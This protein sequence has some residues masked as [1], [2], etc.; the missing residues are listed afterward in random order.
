MEHTKQDHN[1]NTIHSLVMTCYLS[2]N[3]LFIYLN[4]KQQN[5]QDI[6]STSMFMIET[7]KKDKICIKLRELDALK[8]SVHPE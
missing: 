6:C 2:A 4:N 5:G 7:L 3:Y 8:M 1:I